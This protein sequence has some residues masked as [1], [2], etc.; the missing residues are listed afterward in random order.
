MSPADHAH[1]TARTDAQTREQLAAIA[2]A[3]DS[4]GARVWSTP[5]AEARMKFLRCA[6][7]DLAL[8]HARCFWHGGAQ[9]RNIGISSQGITRFDFEA[10]FDRHLPLVV[11]QA[12][13][14]ILFVSSL[15]GMVDSQGVAD[16]AQVYFALASPQ[17]VAVLKR[18]RRAIS[19]VARSRIVSRLTPKEAPR[20]REL[21]SVLERL[22]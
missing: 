17:V 21:A 2:A 20:M 8:F 18:M 19:R 22:D 6:A 7:R 14:V 4:L 15:T 11:L 3:G 16:I 12:F 9:V 5:E 13:D 1:A 10:D